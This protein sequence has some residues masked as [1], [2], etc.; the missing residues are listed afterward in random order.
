MLKTKIKLV[1]KASKNN[2]IQLPKK[3]NITLD[4][5]PGGDLITFLDHYRTKDLERMFSIDDVLLLVPEIKKRTWC[6]WREFNKGKLRNDCV[7]PEY[8]IQG[9][10]IYKIKLIWILRYIKGLKWEPEVEVQVSASQSD[11]MQLRSSRSF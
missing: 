8:V 9:R 3:N 5:T 1:K 6:E 7:G 2:I 4:R 11:D 10:R